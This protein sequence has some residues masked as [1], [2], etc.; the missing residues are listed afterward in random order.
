MR[1]FVAVEVSD[2]KL[3]EEIV[4]LQS[5]IPINAKP[6]SPNNLH[7]TLQFLGEISEKEV[8]EVRGVLRNIKF[9]K[10]TLK[11]EDIGV[12][13]KPS[14]PRVIWIGTDEDGGS[15]LTDLAE[16][17]GNVL[18]PLG[19]K[20]DKPFKSHMTIFRI[21]NKVGNISEMLNNFK[22]QRFGSQKIENLKFKK[23]VL[24]ASGPIY[25][26]LEV[27]ALK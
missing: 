18:E 26:D 4:K 23:S 15:K 19:F 10:F 12:F 22:S 8:D 25:S 1:A 27:I 5:K 16:R 21:K 14:F 11:F 6:V 9:P 2:D 24:T 17:V 13:P 3:I 20:K 7:F